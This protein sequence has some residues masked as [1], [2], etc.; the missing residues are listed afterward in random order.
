MTFRALSFNTV[1]LV[2]G[3]ATLAV[4]QWPSI[5]LM[6]F[7]LLVIPGLIL[8]VLP[9]CFGY[10]T[11]YW[12]ARHALVLIIVSMN[13]DCS[14][15]LAKY[16]AICIT[17]I[18][19]I[20]LP[21]LVRT[22]ANVRLGRVTLPEILPDKPVELSGDVR[23]EGSNWDEAQARARVLL[24]IKDVT[25]VT[26]ARSPDKDFEDFEALTQGKM[27]PSSSGRTY[28]LNQ[29]DN[30]RRFADGMTD[31]DAK[32]CL[33]EGALV[34]RYDFLLRDGSWMEAN[35]RMDDWTIRWPIRI[36]Y[37]EVRS[38]KA[39]LARKWMAYT[40]T[41]QT[42]ILALPT[43]GSVYEPKFCWERTT[44]G[45][46]ANGNSPRVDEFVQGLRRSKP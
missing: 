16:A 22:E 23:I 1:W 28:R 43:C 19:A 14:D 12:I 2:S 17:V 9:V 44:L 46:Y 13:R 5:I 20:V 8:S 18:A 35:K 31:A 11:A 41:L 24:Q 38:N 39:V 21:G 36:D 32:I 33:V 15:R 26:V 30:C 7:I 42:P 6:G 10:C 25:S 45:R 34:T 4:L 29:F 3:L 40:S 37:A 27:S